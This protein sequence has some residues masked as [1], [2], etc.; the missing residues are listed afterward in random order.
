MHRSKIKIKASSFR[1]KILYHP[2][3]NDMMETYLFWPVNL[4]YLLSICGNQVHK[5]QSFINIFCVFGW[6]DQKRP[7]I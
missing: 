5:T 7:R 3:D 4:D 2:Q 1:D 6:D